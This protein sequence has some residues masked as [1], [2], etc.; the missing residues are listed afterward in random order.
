L[1]ASPYAAMQMSTDCAYCCKQAHRQT[2]R[3]TEKQTQQTNR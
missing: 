2:G 1:T 3:Q